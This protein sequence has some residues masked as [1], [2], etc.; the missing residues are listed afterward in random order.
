MRVVLDTNI[1]VSACLKPEGNEAHSLELAASGAITLFASPA[2]MAEYRGVLL[3][4]KF[5]AVHAAAERV[6]ETVS[7]CILI[8][9]PATNLAVASDAEDNRV[10]ECAAHVNA[11]YLVT[12][13]LRHY[14][15]I[16]GQTA[17]L[18][19]RSFL[20]RISQSDKLKGGFVQPGLESSE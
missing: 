8:V 13:N 2:I 15:R 10:L 4:P 5:R 19:A 9:E 12:G 1:L 11:A 16:Y 3:R 18:N 6:L 20:T 17:I 7:R 14:P